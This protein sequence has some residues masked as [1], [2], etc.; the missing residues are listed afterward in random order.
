MD[1]LNVLTIF[2]KALLDKGIDYEVTLKGAEVSV[3]LLDI[4]S[5]AVIARSTRSSLEEALAA[6]M[7][8]AANRTVRM[9]GLTVL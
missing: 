8:C 7:A 6:S 2:T 9:E 4:G 5:D 3:R 1:D